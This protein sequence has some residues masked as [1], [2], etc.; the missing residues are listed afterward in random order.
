MFGGRRCVGWKGQGTVGWSGYSVKGETWPGSVEP[1]LLG[2]RGF[3]NKSLGKGFQARARVARACSEADACLA[4]GVNR[5]GQCWWIKRRV[6][7]RRLEMGQRSKPARDVGP[8]GCHR[9]WLL[10]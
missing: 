3:A 1:R 5:G 2:V 8:H 7:G 4:C 6:K 9:T 10:L